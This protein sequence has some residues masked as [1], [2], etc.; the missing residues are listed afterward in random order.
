M[1]AL[2]AGPN[3]LPSG[4]DVRYWGPI[5]DPA[6]SETVFEKLFREIPWSHEEVV[7]FGKLHVTSRKVAWHG[8]PGSD[9]TY[10]GRR[11]QP[12][13][14][15]EILRALKTR[16]EKAAECHFNSCLLNLYQSG[17]E[18]MGWHR[19]D[20]PELGQEPVIASLSFGAERRFL[21]RRD[22][23]AQTVEVRLEN[24]SLLIMR[25]ATQRHWKHS[26]PKALRVREARINL[27]FRQ[28]HLTA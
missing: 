23:S 7:L 22:Q 5:F 12:A 26:L 11:K 20:E 2:H 10:A 8:D 3:L 19:D 9:Y 16:V 24:G 18:G 4:G 27:T 14:W 6:E 1:A 17:A 28:I 25:G 13:P 15:T 21:F